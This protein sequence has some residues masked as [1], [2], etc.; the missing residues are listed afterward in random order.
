MKIIYRR[1][2]YDIKI[3]LQIT[4]QRV[5]TNWKMFDQTYPMLKA[6]RFGIPF[7]GSAPKNT[8]SPCNTKWNLKNDNIIM[9]WHLNQP[10]E[11]QIKELLYVKIS[12]Y[13]AIFNIHTLIW[14]FHKFDLLNL[15]DWNFNFKI[16]L[17]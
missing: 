14:W 3:R 16:T 1:I 9:F 13:E 8:Y 12:Q 17:Y 4:P 6:L 11:K 7:V 10:E 2:Y 15:I 5:T